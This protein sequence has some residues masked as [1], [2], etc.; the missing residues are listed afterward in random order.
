LSKSLLCRPKRK[1]KKIFPRFAKI[2]S[3]DTPSPTDKDNGRKNHSCQQGFGVMA[4]EVLRMNIIAKFELWCFV[5]TVVLKC[6]HYAK[7]RTVVRQ[8]I[9]TVYQN[10]ELKI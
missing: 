10:R 4:G 8:H 9:Q 1:T 7:P 6:R 2:K 5:S 3:A